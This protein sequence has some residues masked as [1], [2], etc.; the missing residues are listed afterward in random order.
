[1]FKSLNRGVL[2]CYCTYFGLYMYEWSE[3]KTPKNTVPHHWFLP[4]E[5]D[6]ISAKPIVEFV[7]V[8]HRDI[9]FSAL[10]QN[11]SLSRNS[12]YINFM[13]TSSSMYLLC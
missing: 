10:V 8:C 5:P 1:M 7:I 4:L 9:I 11:G 6:F 13:R 12:T 3:D 2:A